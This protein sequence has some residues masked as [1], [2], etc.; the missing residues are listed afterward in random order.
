[1]VQH[2]KIRGQPTVGGGPGG[3]VVVHLMVVQYNH[4][5]VLLSTDASADTPTMD[6]DIQ[7]ELD[8]QPEIMVE[9]GAGEWS[10]CSR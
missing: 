1:M 7:V 6:G 9:G 4:L 2:G 3:S 10:K 8:I 5:Q